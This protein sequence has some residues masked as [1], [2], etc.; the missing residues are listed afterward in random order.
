MFT[1]QCNDIDE[2]CV[3][4]EMGTL[5]MNNVDLKK[6]PQPASP[7]SINLKAKTSW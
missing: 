1:A 5:S 4:D 2:V 6:W 3:C 7:D